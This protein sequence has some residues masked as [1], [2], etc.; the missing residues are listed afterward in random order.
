V[1]VHIISFIK[2]KCGAIEL[3]SKQEEEEIKRQKD[4]LDKTVP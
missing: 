4:V 2:C 1:D 3:E